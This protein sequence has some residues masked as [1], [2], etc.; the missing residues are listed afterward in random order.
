MMTSLKQYF[1]WL[2]LVQEF[3]HLP[4]FKKDLLSGLTV[5][6]ALVPE[7]IAFSF[8]AGVNPM[9][10]L[11][12]AFLV[13]IITA[14]FWWRPGMISGATWA[15]AVVMTGLVVSHGIEMLFAT[16]ILT[17]VLQILF[18]LFW[19]WK[20]VRLIPHSV[21]LWF[22]NGLAIIILLS[23]IEQFKIHESWI[24]WYDLVVMLWLIILTMWLIYFTPKFTRSIPSW[25]VAIWVVT[26]LSL[27]LPFLW[28]VRTV[29]SYLSENGYGN[30]IGSFPLFHIPDISMGFMEMILIIA[31]YSFILAIIWLTES[32]MTLS[33]IDEITDTRWSNNRE[34]IGQ[35]IA[36]GVCW[37]FWAMWGCAMI[38]QSMINISN[39]WRWRWSWVSAA[40]FLIILVV[41]GTS[42]IAIIPIAALIGLMFM[43]VIG[44]FAWPTFKMLFKIPKGDAFVIVAVTV[45]TVIFED[46]ALAVVSWVIISALVFAWE[47]AKLISLERTV[48]AKNITHYKISWLL[49]FASV[50][51]FKELFKIDEDTKEV[52][53]DFADSRVMDLSAIEAI[54]SLT[55]KYKN[56]GKKLHLIHLSSDC[57]NKINNANDFVDINILEDPKY[58]V[59]NIQL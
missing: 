35:G 18:W 57:I 28:E 17:G 11:H 22:V 20:L 54:N 1:L 13:G 6:L 25:L 41:F 40:L 42:V 7:A 59:A 15:M 45:I 38:G 51:N 19:L 9:V 8:V 43:V 52:F 47:K 44:T 12:A 24:V 58:Y 31:P 23:Q 33:L 39:G 36:N 30:L 50:S 55:E 27:L 3:S 46:L 53:I 16:L 49:Y 2:E 37:L 32:L 21:M 56:S 26:I 4:Q 34:A 29:A 5:A 14:I 10:W 48:D